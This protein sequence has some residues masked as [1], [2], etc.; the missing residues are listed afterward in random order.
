MFAFDPLHPQQNAIIEIIALSPNLTISELHETLKRRYNVSISLQHVYRLVTQMVEEQMVLKTKGKLTLNLMW[1]SYVGLFAERAR[2][3]TAMATLDSTMFPL[4]EGQKKS[5]SANSLMGVETIWNHLLIQLY[6]STLEKNLFKY[7]SHAWWQLE[8]VETQKKAYA[9][10]AKRGINCFYVFG[11]NGFL[12]KKGA[13]ILSPTFK[14]TIAKNPPFPTEGYNLNVY[15]E[16]ILEC[17]FPEKLTKHLE[18]FFDGVKDEASFDQ[19]LFL[20][21]FTKRAACKVTVWRNAKQAEAL[22]A[23]IE[24]CFS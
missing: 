12:D 18:F 14:A 7:Y 4:E 15:G 24:Q 20:D 3:S 17:V 21:L 16:Y 8:K 13:E 5:L 23:K 22:R 9:E 1:L 6:Q 11:N 2:M 19:E 10:I